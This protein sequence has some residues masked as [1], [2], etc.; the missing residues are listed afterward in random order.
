M[1]AESVLEHSDTGP[2]ARVSLAGSSSCSR[3]FTS[4]SG[5]VVVL[6]LPD[7]A[8]M[9]HL[10]PSPH[11]DP[12]AVASS[13]VIYTAKA[14]HLSTLSFGGPARDNDFG[15][16]CSISDRAVGFCEFG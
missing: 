12:T 7:V 5:V 9:S 2:E 16:H 4:S 8:S 15:R 3:G 1:L 6:V 10:L 13:S 14:L 11:R